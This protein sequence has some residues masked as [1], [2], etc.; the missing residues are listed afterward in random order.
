MA[1]VVVSPTARKDLI[2]I[3]SYICDELQNPDAAAKLMD[4][5]AE[6]V[7]SL[8]EMPERGTPLNAII[9][10]NTGFRFLVCGTYR[11]F[12]LCS[13]DTVEVIRIL[14]RLQNYVKALI[15]E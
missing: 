7:E 3:H 4:A 12:Y 10:I 8:S 5:L 1:R 6:K 9:P 11:I 13:E 14:N 15:G 2:S